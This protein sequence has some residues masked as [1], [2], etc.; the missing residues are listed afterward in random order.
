[1]RHQK[2]GRR[3]VITGDF[4]LSK[5]TPKIGMLAAR[6]PLNELHIQQTDC[7]GH[8]QFVDVMRSNR[9]AALRNRYL[10][11]LGA[12]PPSE[13][14]GAAAV[15]TD[16]GDFGATAAASVSESAPQRDRRI[17]SG[18][19]GSEDGEDV[20]E[21]GGVGGRAA[22]FAASS[23]T[24]DDEESSLVSGTRDSSHAGLRVGGRRM[25]D[26]SEPDSLTELQA[27]TGVRSGTPSS[28]GPSLL[29][30]TLEERAPAPIFAL[31]AGASA[32]MSSSMPAL[33]AAAPVEVAD[34]SRALLS[35]SASAAPA[36]SLE[37]IRE[38]DEDDEDED[39]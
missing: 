21:G 26:H 30:H 38:Q 35:I 2:A 33:A 8:T 6:V 36:P 22:S 23:V 14:G 10:A 15:R 24:G 5:R 17:E 11:A 3:A 18:V 13:T 32:L 34:K 12:P 19:E 31:A 25:S 29:G 4:E 1:M 7:Y 16:A 20:F 39:G 9:G 28:G 27:N 37:H